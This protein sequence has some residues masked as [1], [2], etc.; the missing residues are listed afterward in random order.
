MQLLFDTRPSLAS[1]LTDFGSGRA[2][3]DPEAGR[4]K[5]R[6]CVEASQALF[7]VAKVAISQ[8]V[9]AFNG[10]EAVATSAAPTVRVTLRCQ[11]SD[12]L[13]LTVTDTGVARADDLKVS[14]RTRLS[15]GKHLELMIWRRVGRADGQES[16]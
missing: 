10:W 12:Q 14:S 2:D 11:G 15:G 16:A 13:T 6:S 9:A 1:M 5:A 8:S 3:N 4:W 7:M